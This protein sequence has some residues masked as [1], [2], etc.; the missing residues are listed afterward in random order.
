MC[1]Y[2]STKT[3]AHPSRGSDSCK[4]SQKHRRVHLHH[5]TR[6][7]KSTPSCIMPQSHSPV[8]DGSVSGFGIIRLVRVSCFPACLTRAM[9]SGW[10][11]STRGL[12]RC[13]NS[14]I[15][16]PPGGIAAL[17]SSSVGNVVAGL[18]CG[19]CARLPVADGVPV[20]LFLMGIFARPV[21]DA[22]V[23]LPEP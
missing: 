12:N 10:R 9:K 6:S 21:R 2:P 4:V 11:F 17:T 22:S 5:S 23:S 7:N 15:S 20:G 19:L 14:L 13:A 1:I 16:T 8:G 18:R 3:D